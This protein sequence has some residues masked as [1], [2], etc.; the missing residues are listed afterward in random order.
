[1][2]LYREMVLDT[3][4]PEASAFKVSLACRQPVEFYGAKT[5]AAGIMRQLVQELLA[6]IAQKQSKRSVG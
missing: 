6:R 1:R 4:V 5:Q 3:T 2:D